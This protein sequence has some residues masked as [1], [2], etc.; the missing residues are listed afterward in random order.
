M[1][2]RRAVGYVESMS[3]DSRPA[4]VAGLFYPA[5]PQAPLALIAQC[6]AGALLA[7]RAHRLT[8]RLL[9]LRNSGDAG[10]DRARVVGY[11]AI[12]FEAAP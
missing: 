4:A 12:A 5:Q 3:V 7:A 8:P 9:D 10:G 1:A 6:L 2:E 11:C